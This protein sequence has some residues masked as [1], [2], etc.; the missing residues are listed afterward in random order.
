[1]KSIHPYWTRK[2]CLL[3]MFLLGMTPLAMS[4][5]TTN[6]EE[7]S[8]PQQQL[9][10]GVVRDGNGKALEGVT[11]GLSGTELT[12]PTDGN[13]RFSI[14]ATVGSRLEFRL[15]GYETTY[16][17]VSSTASITIVLKAGVQ[18]IDDVV[19]TGYQNL[20][21]RKF[22][23]AAKTL[24][25]EDVKREGIADVSRMLEGQVAGVSVQNVSG[26]FGAAPKIRVRGASSISGDN[27]PLWVVDGI[28][29]EDVINVS[30]EQLS[31]G[32]PATLI[33]SSV[34]GLN[35]DDIESFE[36]LKD[37][38]ATSL[39]GARAMNGVIVISTKKGKIGEP[40]FSYTG[41]FSTYLK[42]NY[43]QFNIMNS[44]DQMSIYAE[45]QRKG[46]LN[47]GQTSRFENGGVFVKMAEL[48]NTY[49]QTSGKF[50]L[51]NDVESRRAFLNRYAQANT[52][53]FDILFQNSLMQEHAISVSTGTEKSQFYVST[54]YLKDSGWSVGDAVNRM[55]GNVR[56]SFTPN[57][58]LT[59]GIITQGS[60]RN[61]QAPGTLGRQSN[62]VS[63]SFD[64]YFDINPFS[65]ALNT[66]RVITAY[67]EQ[68][69]LEYFRRN[70][71]PFNILQELE[72]NKINLSFMDFK[73]QGELRYKLLRESNLQ[74]A[75]EGA[76]RYAKTNQEHRIHENS[77]MPRAYRA[78]DDATIRAANK[79]LYRDPD[80]IE[81]EP[82]VI[83]PYGGF[84]KTNDNNL[85]S[86]NLRNSLDYTLNFG[87]DHQIKT[88]GFMELRYADRQIKSFDGY[89]YQFDKGGVP[90]VDPKFLKMM[91]E[92]NA[93]YYEMGERYDR[94][95]AYG[96][97]SGYTL[98]NK[99]NMAG[100][101]RYD[102]SNLMGRT[103][104]ARWLPTWNV[105]GSWNVDGEDFFAKQQLI[106]RATL[107]ASYGLTASSGPATNSSLV[108][109]NSAANRP[110]LTERE[111]V[112]FIQNI[113]N[114]EL[115]WEKMYKANIGFDISFLDNR[116]NLT[117]DYYDHR[118]FDLI[119]MV[120]TG[121]I[122]GEAFK[123]ANYADMKA[124]GLEFT[125]GLSVINKEKW[126]WNSQLN[127]GYNYSEITKLRNEPNIWSLV[128]TD[129]GAKEGYAQRGLFSIQ[130]QGLEE[131]KGYP[132]F[133]NEKGET[134][135]GVYLQDEQT[136]YLKYE[137]SIDPLLTGGFY[138]AVSFKDFRLSALLTFSAGNV[139]RL[140]PAFK[141]AYSELDAMPEEFLNRWLM[142]GDAAEPSI[143]DGRISANFVGSFP[144]NNY[145]YSTQRVAKGD[146]I[147]LKQLML[148][149]QIPQKLIKSARL[150][151]ASLGLVANNLWLI[152]SDPA[153]KGQ[154][155]E[156]FGSGGVAMPVPRQFTLS[157]KL[158]F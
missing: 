94:F 90:Y 101:V 131:E 112:I 63:G 149:Y 10:S 91:V 5:V 48:I 145:N 20:S 69:D 124:H 62:V 102:G 99:Y 88:Y 120:R 113:E 136:K 64:R 119:G 26:T 111:S 4:T 58:R 118:S 141:S 9:V 35:P 49:D 76:Y 34:A 53:W 109:M 60:I 87:M 24:K 157:A 116:Y 29:L 36:I 143:V 72:N 13:G 100:T 138:N 133:I 78:A 84:Y 70:F 128:N 104:T 3:S 106:N 33:G 117:V 40:I 14:R 132:L 52:N 41:N 31:T 46:W 1:M 144:Y 121:G 80:N 89:G 92:A 155:P 61:Q 28:I 158:G 93:N 50:G 56:A 12:V 140:R 22:T 37:A 139:V 18:V 57:K 156:F 66:S 23:G 51:K 130:Y 71:A 68:G 152:Y 65:Y 137:G 45:M 148:N 11:V 8:R 73:M 146:F 30:N 77:N 154:D 151:T 107:R 79:Y 153:L 67:D 127:F 74:Y 39:Y 81:A 96:I 83:L 59:Y 54:S 114:S 122:D 21:K 110:Y 123:L 134:S 16:H 44:Y 82:I 129:G 103:R 125:L 2:L 142:F 7:I 43:D 98:K 95:L 135:P 27:K 97:N 32:D 15:L 38:A 108:L 86:F 115:T 25:A 42:P 19:V 150:K 17:T 6:I 147:R 47:F 55:T 85:N 126:K 105:S 75:F